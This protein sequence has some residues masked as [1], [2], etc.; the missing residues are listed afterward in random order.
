MMCEVEI[1]AKLWCEDDWE[2]LIGT[3]RKRRE[4]EGF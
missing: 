1:T 4:D 2:N 3:G